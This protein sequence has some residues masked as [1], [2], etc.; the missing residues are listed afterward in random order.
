MSLSAK[1]DENLKQAMLARESDKVSVL[2]MLK[3]ALKYVAV[4]KGGA[5]TVL[6]D[7]DVVAVIRKE[8]K[9]RADSIQSFEQAKRTDLV[10]KE[11]KEAAILEAYLPAGLKP[12]EIEAL[13]KDAIRETGATSKA[14]MGLVMKAAQTKAAGR[15]DGKTLSQLVQKNLP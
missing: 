9:K 6:S 1:I 4:E 7:T 3:S 10:E 13:V 14:Q 11:K 2:R 5:D 15:V 12:E 8:L